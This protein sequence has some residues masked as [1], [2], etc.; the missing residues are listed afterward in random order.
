MGIVEWGAIVATCMLLLTVSG[1]IV[2]VTLRISEAEKKAELAQSRADMAGINVAANTMRVETVAKLLSDHK[3]TIAQN[4]VSNRSLEA[5]ENRLVDAIG[6]LGDRIDRI[7]MS[8][9]TS[10]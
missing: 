5:L 7:F 8:K 4:Y 1:Y 9:A 3:E 6:K 2:K 10:A